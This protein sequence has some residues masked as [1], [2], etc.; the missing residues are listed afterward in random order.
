MDRLTIATAVLVVALGPAGAVAAEE[1]TAPTGVS[2]HASAAHS[3]SP[4]A[5]SLS[6]PE[7]GSVTVE[8]DG[9]VDMEGLELVGKVW[10]QTPV[11]GSGPGPGVEVFHLPIDRAE[12]SVSGR[13]DIDAGDYYMWVFAGPP[14][15]D[16]SSMPVCGGSFHA[17]ESFCMTSFDVRPHEDIRISLAG[18]PAMPGGEMAEIPTPCPIWLWERGTAPG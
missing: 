16:A 9:L 17:T 7:P 12:F 4:E 11:G 15:C 2:N 3:P 13:A 6:E 5:T 1:E 14:P 10:R 8:V 18:L